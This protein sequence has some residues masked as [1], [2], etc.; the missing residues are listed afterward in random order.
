MT[1]PH[2][3]LED[4]AILASFEGWSEDV[5]RDFLRVRRGEMSEAEFSDKYHYE[6]AILSMDM[7]GFTAAAMHR[8]ELDSMLRILDAQKVCLPVL[9]DLGAE[10]IRCFADDVV[11]IFLDVDAAVDAA[12]ETHRRIRL[13]NQSDLAS[14]HPTE[15]CAGIGFGRVFAIG[16]NLAQGDEM[17]RASKLGEDIARANETL[18][19][20]RA[21]EAVRHR[22]DLI[23]ERQGQDDQFFPFYRTISKN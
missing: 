12:L 13:F 20:E 4:A 8:G 23:F 19:T 18:L 17:N 22:D 16:P 14:E 21:F 7:T 5:Y 10:I 15:C 11:A 9:R 3:L 1:Y 6:R 2:D